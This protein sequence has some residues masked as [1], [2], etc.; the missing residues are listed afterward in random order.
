MGTFWWN[1]FAKLGYVN[2]SNGRP[3]TVTYGRKK[4]RGFGR[5]GKIRGFGC[6]FGIR[7]NTNTHDYYQQWSRTHYSTLHTH[8]LWCGAALGS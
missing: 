8:T 7:N 4:L 2:L 1:K 3:K 6:G 5:T